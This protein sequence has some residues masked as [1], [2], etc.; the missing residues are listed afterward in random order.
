MYF[1][2]FVTEKQNWLASTL[3][4]FRGNGAPHDKNTL[5]K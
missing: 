2:K 5:Q 3:D 1:L 4:A